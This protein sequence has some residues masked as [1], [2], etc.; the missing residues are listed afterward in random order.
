MDQKEGCILLYQAQ[1][2]AKERG[3][4]VGLV[5][6]GL[7]PFCEGQKCTILERYKAIIDKDWED[8]KSKQN[9]GK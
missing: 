9:E 3:L 1:E 6:C 7:L 2:L 5:V 8:K 4:D